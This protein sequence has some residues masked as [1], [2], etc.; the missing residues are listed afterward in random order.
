[1][2]VWC[3]APKNTCS[4]GQPLPSP[5]E[6]EGCKKRTQ[7]YFC[8]FG[9]QDIG[10]ILLNF[11]K[12]SSG[13]SRTFVSSSPPHRS[14]QTPVSQASKN[15][16]RRWRYTLPR[17][18]HRRRRRHA[19][20]CFYCGIPLFSP[21]DEIF[22]NF[23]GSLPSWNKNFVESGYSPACILCRCGY[24][25]YQSSHPLSCMGKAEAEQFA[26][27]GQGALLLLWLRCH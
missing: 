18:Q 19:H 27:N 13:R 14:P 24:S 9:C 8:H 4:P 1:M 15:G 3:V 10:G 26:W 5:H 17:H 6:F 22:P 23:L 2:F 11:S 21:L 12:F 25:V 16:K 20:L 7:G